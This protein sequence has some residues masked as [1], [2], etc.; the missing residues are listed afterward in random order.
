MCC[1]SIIDQRRGRIDRFLDEPVICPTVLLDQIHAKRSHAHLSTLLRALPSESCR[2]LVDR[3]NKS[4]SK[5][6]LGK[7]RVSGSYAS[8]LTRGRDN[9]I[10]R[11]ASSLWRT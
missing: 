10:A 2:S 6:R 5:R 4:I 11:V 9:Q 8:H 7:L 1:V 3:F